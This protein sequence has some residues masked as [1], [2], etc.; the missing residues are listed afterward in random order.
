VSSSQYKYANAN[1]GHLR[2]FAF[3]RQTNPAGS[4][5]NPESLLS[6]KTQRDEAAQEVEE[7][8]SRIRVQF[9]EVMAWLTI[10]RAP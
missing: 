2:R 3:Q 6:M 1:L 4:L 8:S 9:D 10:Q 7:E 5:S